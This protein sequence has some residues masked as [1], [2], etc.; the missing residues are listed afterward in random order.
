MVVGPAPATAGGSPANLFFNFIRM[1]AALARLSNGSVTPLR[2]EAAPRARFNIVPVEYVAVAVVALAEHE[3]GAGETFHIVV[4]EPPTQAAMLEMLA[5]RFGM[6]GL[7]L[8]DPRTATLD[9]PSPLERA[10]A[11]SLAGYRAYLAPDVHLDHP[12]TPPIPH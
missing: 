1:T 11:R 3:D 12:T 2:I 4:S 10:V 5:E 7:S 6:R 8:V 9:D